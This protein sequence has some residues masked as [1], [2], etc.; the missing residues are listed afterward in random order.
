ME[1]VVLIM[2]G[3]SMGFKTRMAL[4]GTPGTNREARFS[5]ALMYCSKFLRVA[6][7]ADFDEI[8]DEI[9]RRAAPFAALPIPKIKGAADC[10]PQ[11]I[12]E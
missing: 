1:T 9:S 12:I 6:G 2:A 10:P 3:G 8:L 5:V 4:V 11:V 7:P